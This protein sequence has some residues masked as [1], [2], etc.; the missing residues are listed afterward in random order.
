LVK[1][2][3]GRLIISFSTSAKDSHKHGLGCPGIYS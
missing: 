2:Q 1:R 3:P